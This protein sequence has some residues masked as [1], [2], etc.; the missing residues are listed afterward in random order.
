MSESL[1]P[2]E[3]FNSPSLP[4]R[5]YVSNR[6]LSEFMGRITEDI[7]L[8]ETKITKT[9][10]QAFMLHFSVGEFDMAVFDPKAGSCEI[11]G[12]KHSAEAAKQ[13]AHHLTDAVKTQQPSTATAQSRVSSCCTAVKAA[14]SAES[15][16]EMW[17]SI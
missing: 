1:L 9:Q 7:V 15:S 6:I 10:K 14:R 2:D 13:Q 12:N 5:T 17:R 8:L 11:Y 3:A 4:E 16:I